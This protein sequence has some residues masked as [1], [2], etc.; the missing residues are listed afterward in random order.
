MKKLALIAGSILLLLSSCTTIEIKEHDLFDVK[1]TIRPQ[2]FR[3][4]PYELDE[5]TL[6]TP[7]SI[8]LQAWFIE[9]PGAEKT[10][11]YF[12]GNGFV[13]EIGYNIITS[14][15]KQ[16]VNLLVFNYRGYGRNAGSPSIEGF[17]KDGL[18]VYDYLIHERNV[19]PRNIILHGHSLGSFIA[20]Y[21]ANQR[22]SGALVL[23]NPVTDMEDWTKTA[24]PWFLRAILNFEVDRTLVENSN[25]EQIKRVE[26]PIFIVS[27]QEDKITPPTLAEKLYE[28]ATNTSKKKL[29]I[30]EGGGHNNLPEMGAYTQALR[31]FY[32]SPT[33]TV[34]K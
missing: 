21:T 31:R 9:N 11:L 14:I 25:L 26:V 16:N 24:I 22:Q 34:L 17:Q 2:M 3:N 10:V 6:T 28:T 8:S 30:V 27:G 20:A 12:G 13:I 32:A 1:R 23:Q 15:V 5:L 7:D 19:D 29:L 18:A 33:S 4:M